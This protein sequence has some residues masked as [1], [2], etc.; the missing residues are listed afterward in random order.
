VIGKR[1]GIVNQ[2][3]K[4]RKET[5]IRKEGGRCQKRKGPYRRGMAQVGAD[6]EDHLKGS[7][8]FYQKGESEQGKGG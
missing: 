3:Q 6:S 5:R 2:A 1:G 4:K 8:R 7:G